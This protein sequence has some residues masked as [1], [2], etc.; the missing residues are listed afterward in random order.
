MTSKKVGVLSLGCAKNLVDSEVMLGNL[1]K[2]GYTLTPRAEDADVVIVN[3]CG[4]I[5]SAKEESVETI[6]E[7]AALKQSGKLE[8]LIVS[9]CLSQRYHK[10]MEKEMPE[11]DLFLGTG[12]PGQITEFLKNPAL[13]VPQ[14]DPNYLYNSQSERILTTPSHSAYVKISE[15][16]DHTCSFCIIPALRG[17]H[18]SRTIEDIVLEAERLTRQGVVELNLVAQ[19]STFYGRDLGLKDGLA[20]LLEALV[21]VPGIQWIRVHYMYPHQVSSKLLDIMNRHPVVCSYLDIPL[22]HAS[23]KILASMRRGGDGTSYARFLDSIR[24]KMPGCFL[25]S[26]FI[27]GYP[28]EGQAEYQELLD[29]VKEQE[30]N[31]LGVFTYSHEEGTSAFGMEDSIPAEIKEERRS[32]L[33]LLQK[34]ISE[35][36]CSELKGSTLPVLIEGVHPETELLLKGRHQGQAPDVDGLVFVTEGTYQPGEIVSVTIEETYEYDL[37]GRATGGISV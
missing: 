1:V 5:D 28:G 16:C 22:Q 11:V 14:W 12:Q 24:D 7:M 2:E 29:F 15:G 19:D 9:G 34:S 27:V 33:M 37:A 25:R 3:T 13:S 36:K 17:K 4:F 18:R 35:K 20:L 8:R 10:E 21:Q 31:Y 30:F 23:R 6:L 32:E 26:S